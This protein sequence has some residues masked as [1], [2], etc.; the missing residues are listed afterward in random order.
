[1]SDLKENSSIAALLPWPPRHLR[2]VRSGNSTN[3]IRKHQQCHTNTVFYTFITGG[4][5][6]VIMPTVLFKDS[7]VLLCNEQGLEQN[8]LRLNIYITYKALPCMPLSWL[9]E[10]KRLAARQWLLLGNSVHARTGGD[11]DGILV[12]G[13]FRTTLALSLFTSRFLGTAES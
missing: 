7:A 12:S 1:M 13:G 11:K 6:T 3:H 10:N 8:L 4:F 5:L 9:A 2:R